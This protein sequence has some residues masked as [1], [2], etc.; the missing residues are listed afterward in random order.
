ML[1]LLV[2]LLPTTIP[3]AR[4]ATAHSL[5][6]DPPALCDA[7]NCKRCSGGAH[8]TPTFCLQCCPDCTLV[9]TPPYTYCNCSSPAPGPAPYPPAPA[10]LF[11][12]PSTSCWC[13]EVYADAA[14]VHTAA[15]PYRTI[16]N[17]VE[18]KTQTLLFDVW[19]PPGAM[20]QGGRPVALIVH[21]GGFS[22]GTYNGCSH[23][24]DMHSFALQAAKFAQ[25]GFVA[26]SIDYRCY[27]P[28]REKP[29][30]NVTAPWKAAVQDARAAIL[31]LRTA[32]VSA[33]FNLDMSKLFVFG[34]SAGA[35]TGAMLAFSPLDPVREINANVTAACV[36]SGSVMNHSIVAGF[37]KASTASPAYLDFHGTNDSTVPYTRALNP[38]G[39]DYW[40]TALHTE[41]WGL[42]AGADA[43]LMPIP[44]R[45]HVPFD[46][47]Y[48]APFN[49]TMFGFLLD[50]LSLNDVEC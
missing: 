17:V 39:A 47:L 1:H 19:A 27:G 36:L 5:S 20:K 11:A 45:G 31:H 35:A 3:L 33:K 15:V 41:E 24:R 40:G 30:L 21:G 48:E 7:P 28:L 44:G 9:A 8:G 2:G 16:F 6:C 14:I 22:T 10:P 32:A 26:V 13:T 38:N 4:A 37:A 18:N 29:T 43:S 12:C 46:A 50:R 23:A 34:G 25:H 49:T 42:A